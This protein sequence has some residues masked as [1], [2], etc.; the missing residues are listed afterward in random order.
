MPFD[1]DYTERV[2]LNIVK[3]FG[4]YHKDTNE[5]VVDGARMNRNDIGTFQVTI[6]GEFSKE[7]RVYIRRQAAL[8]ITIYDSSDPWCGMPICPDRDDGKDYPDWNDW[9]YKNL[10]PETYNNGTRPVPYIHSLSIT[11]LLRI[12]WNKEMAIPEQA[13]EIPDKKVAVTDWSAFS[14]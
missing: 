5:I 2:H 13:Y 1:Y 8:F 12:G 9:P 10:I 14:P 6:V 7:G 4:E 11:G 3:L